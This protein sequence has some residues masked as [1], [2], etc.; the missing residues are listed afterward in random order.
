[1]ERMRRSMGNQ[2][3]VTGDQL[4]PWPRRRRAPP[5]R[6][7]LAKMLR[8]IS[9]LLWLCDVYLG[10]VWAMKHVSFETKKYW[11]AKGS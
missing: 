1:M 7:K 9:H 6:E 8:A 10:E 11:E 5:S 4:A 3:N 2:Q